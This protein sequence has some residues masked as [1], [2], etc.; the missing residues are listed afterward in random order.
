[1]YIAVPGLLDHWKELEAKLEMAICGHSRTMQLSPYSRI[2]I[3]TSEPVPR[4]TS[5]LG[6]HILSVVGI[7]GVSFLLMAIERVER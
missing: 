5:A 7:R 2:P 1:M 3:N 4:P 6:F